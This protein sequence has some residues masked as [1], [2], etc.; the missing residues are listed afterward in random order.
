MK[1]FEISSL[2]ALQDL[3]KFIVETY[4]EERCFLFF[5]EMGTGK[6]TLIKYICSELGIEEH[7]SS[8]TYSIVNEYVSGEKRVFHFD[9]Y[10]LKNQEELLDIGFEEY[11]YSDAFLFIEWPELSL[12]FI[13]EFIAIKIKKLE[14][15]V[16][17][18]EILKEK[19]N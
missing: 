10:R 18:F 19:N 6:T 12:D 16:R 7:T 17:S 4:S 15:Q 13:D 8:P 1:T 5:G 3:A 11:V 9:L 14:E 2:P